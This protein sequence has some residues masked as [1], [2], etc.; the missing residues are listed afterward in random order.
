MSHSLHYYTHPENPKVIMLGIYKFIK[1]CVHSCV[2]LM[3]LKGLAGIARC[4]QAFCL[5]ADLI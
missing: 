1:L 2:L 5:L 3:L 4:V